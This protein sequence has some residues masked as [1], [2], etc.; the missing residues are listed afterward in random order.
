VCVS[1]YV[2]VCGVCVCEVCVGVCV[3]VCVCL[4]RVC[5]CVCVVCMCVCGLACVVVCVCA[6]CRH[7]IYTCQFTEV[8]RTQ[9]SYRATKEYMFTERDKYLLISGKVTKGSAAL[10]DS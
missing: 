7:L 5:V 2:G 6:Q 1:V 10:C 8:C 3:G 9:K 4:E